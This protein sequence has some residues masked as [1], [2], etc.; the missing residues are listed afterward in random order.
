MKGNL[1]IAGGNIKGNIIYKEFIKLA[2][3][4]GKIAIVPTASED[5]NDALIYNTDIFEKCGVDKNDIVG[6][7][8][9]IE[10]PSY[11]DWKKCGDDFESLDFLDDV[12]GVWFCGG[13][14][15]RIIRGFKRSDGT[16]TKLLK[17]INDILEEG[18]VIGGS[19]A[20]AAIMSEVMIGGGTSLGALTKTPY[21][22]YIEY[23]KK[24]ELEE[25]GVLLITKGL[26][27]FK[28]GIIDQHF[29]ERGRHGRLLEVLLTEKVNKGYGIAEDTAIVYDVEKGTARIIGSGGVTIIDTSNA[30]KCKVD[31]YSKI[32][33][34]EISYLL[35]ED[36]YNINEDR[37]YFSDRNRI[38]DSGHLMSNNR[39]DIFFSGERK[40]QYIRSYLEGN[41]DMEY[42]IRLYK[43]EENSKE[44]IKKNTS[45][46]NLI[47][48]L[49]PVFKKTEAVN[50]AAKP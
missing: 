36:I 26:G 33:N 39:K 10:K 25:N 8:V 42:E 5:T 50:E 49:I 35:G 4:C 21:Y 13:D 41:K 27:F 48:D 46:V 11:G 15:I 17:K 23:R 14:Q 32:T 30:I 37:F 1:V 34:V 22:D 16:E 24:P 12:K 7:K 44:S 38:R 18:G 40:M 29:D 47:M 28:G 31:D 3:N 19:S 43:K 45:F 20:G 6:V 9:N 2:G